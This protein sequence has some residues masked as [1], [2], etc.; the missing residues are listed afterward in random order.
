MAPY[1]MRKEKSRPDMTKYT[2]R[3]TVKNTAHIMT[4]LFSACNAMLF[5]PPFFLLASPFVV[6]EWRE[7]EGWRM[8]RY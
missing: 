4:F 5:L 8:G 2:K 7:G 3:V 6:A 1:V